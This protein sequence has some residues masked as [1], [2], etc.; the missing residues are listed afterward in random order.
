MPL[1]FQKI[2]STGILLVFLI[3]TVYA[4]EA[5]RDLSIPL[6]T[7]MRN[8]QKIRILISSDKAQ[9]QVS[10]PGSFD[11]LDEQG[12]SVLR[13]DQLAGVTIKP[14]T[15]GFQWWDQVIPSQLLVIQSLGQGIRI[16]QTGTYRDRILVIKNGK[17]KL[18]LINQLDLDDYLKSVIPFEGNPKWGLEALKAQAVVARTFAMT[19]MIEREKEEY[20]VPSGMLSQVYVGK[21]SENEKTS[22]AVDATHGQFLMYQ[23]KLFPAYYHSTCG[24]ATTAADLVWRVKPHS[25]LSGVECK[26]CQN[27]P[28][29]RWEA[30]VSRAEI[31]EK[32]AKHG[33]P[34]QEVLAVRMGKVDRTGRVHQLIIKSTWVERPV[35][36]DA[37]RVW[38]DPMHL[39]SNL[40]TKIRDNGD[41]TFTFKGK[42]W[43]H[44]VGLCQFGM[45]YL[46]ELGYSYQD[47]LGYYYPRA[48]LSTIQ[49]G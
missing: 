21:N 1:K 8:F 28:H 45:K 41:G 35:D 46:A 36:A 29:F 13:G 6:P 20:D 19:R 7:D 16:G 26:Y 39:K 9:V 31:K 15:G 25:A 42:G 37:F 30:K 38:V 2:L 14:V 33:L 10:S 24:G 27:S 18:D 5:V 3:G 48:Q 40:I 22:Q 32:L 47:I 34:V 23:K 44:G 12:K 11:V 43:G 4:G 17:G 49:G